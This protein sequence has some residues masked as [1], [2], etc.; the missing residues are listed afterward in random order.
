MYYKLQRPIIYTLPS[1]TFYMHTVVRGA[2]TSGVQSTVSCQEGAPHQQLN[3]VCTL[4]TNLAFN[5]YLRNKLSSSL[6]FHVVS[7]YG[8]VLMYCAVSVICA[9][10][11]CDSVLY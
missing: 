6:L 3:G 9:I 4:I 7:M 2:S 8:C 1:S 5:V 10:V 11:F